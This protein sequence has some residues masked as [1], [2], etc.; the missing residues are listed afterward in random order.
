MGLVGGAALNERELCHARGHEI[1]WFIRG[2]LLVGRWVGDTWEVSRLTVRLS[3]GLR[4]ARELIR[5]KRIGYGSERS[6]TH[7]GLE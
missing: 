7:L 6:V 4:S 1:V 5:C 3:E 2:S